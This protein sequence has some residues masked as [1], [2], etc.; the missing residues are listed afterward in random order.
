MVLI[1]NNLKEKYRI[2]KATQSIDA[3]GGKTVSYTAGWYFFG[4]NVS[5]GGQA[6]MGSSMQM[7]DKINERIKRGLR[8]R[9]IDVDRMTT[10]DR[11][12]DRRGNQYRI[13]AIIYTDDLATAELS[14]EV[15][16]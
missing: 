8:V 5:S 2:F 6:G 13:I 7:A 1:G 10:V 4:E 3:A 11:I 14:L 16:Q 9:R 15:V 12:E